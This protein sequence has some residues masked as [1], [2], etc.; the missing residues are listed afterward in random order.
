MT[1]RRLL[2]SSRLF[3]AAG[4][5]S[6]FAACSSTPKGSGAVIT[7]VNPYHLADIAEPIQ[8]ADPSIPF[9]RDEIL[10]GAIS[11][12]ERLALQGNYFS[13]FWELDDR[14]PVTVRL[15]Y[16]QKNTGLTV[17]TVETEVTDVRRSNVTKFS[18]NGA[19][20]VTNGSVVSWRASLV[21]GKQTL[22]EYKSYLW[23]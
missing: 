19:D 3:L 21:R 4:L 9:R 10:H 1:F 8:A 15:E 18:F 13:I 5:V 17:K 22:A 7:K 2:L 11:N 12:E 6:L 16:R 14:Q 20:Y 23:E